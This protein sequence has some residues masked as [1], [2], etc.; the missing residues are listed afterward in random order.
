M[1]KYIAILSLLGGFS[2][3]MA[4][5]IEL[6]NQVP[7]EIE[8][9]TAYSSAV[10]ISQSGPVMRKRTNDIKE[11]H[12]KL[13]T[14][15]SSSPDETD[16]TPFTTALGTRVRPGIAAAIWL[17]FGTKIRMPE[18]VG[19]RVFV[20]E[21]RMHSRFSNRLDI[22]FPEKDQAKNFGVKTLQIEVL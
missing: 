3:A 19:D 7:I 4:A 12:V 11:T 20:I 18:L 10:L 6:P 2:P 16:D 14:A 13:V 1:L 22:W 9:P 21:D 8:E 5:T 15:Y 17:P